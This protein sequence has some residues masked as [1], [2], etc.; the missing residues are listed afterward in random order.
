MTIKG[1]PRN[2]D[3]VS[4]AAC[5]HCQWLE[6]E[7]EGCVCTLA[8]SGRTRSDSVRGKNRASSKGR[9]K[10]W[11]GGKPQK[12]SGIDLWKW[13][14]PERDALWPAPDSERLETPIP[15]G[16]IHNE[17]LRE[18]GKAAKKELEGIALD[19]ML[20]GVENSTEESDPAE[21]PPRFDVY[22]LL[23]RSVEGKWV[24]PTDPLDEVAAGNSLL[25]GPREPDLPTVPSPPEIAPL[26]PES[27]IGSDPLENPEDLLDPFGRP[28]FPLPGSGNDGFGPGI[29]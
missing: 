7:D 28:L 22:D 3:E 9:G 16:I 26:S 19:R 13:P 23:E 15:D 1:C 21:T 18:E 5:K 11:Q 6:E 4:E 27:T 8:A 29:L 14:V 24:S 25:N 17:G 12:R 10:G 20:T 2:N